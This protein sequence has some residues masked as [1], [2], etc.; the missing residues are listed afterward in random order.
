M[1]PGHKEAGHRHIPTLLIS[2]VKHQMGLCLCL[3][4]SPAYL[5]YLIPC[6][7]RA[8]INKSHTSEPVSDFAYWESNMS[9]L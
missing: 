5:L 9:N 3:S 6:L 4:P 7:L 2:E 8:S 1:T